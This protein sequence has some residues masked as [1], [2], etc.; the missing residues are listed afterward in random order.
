M[1]TIEVYESAMCCSTG[2]CGPDVPQELVSFSA[3]V[4]WLKNQGA[5][6][7]R[8]N[9][10]SEAQAFAE[11]PQVLQ[12][13]KVSGSEH[14]PLVLVDGTVARTGTYPARAELARWAGIEGE[15][16]TAP[17]PGGRPELSMVAASGGCCGGG[18]TGC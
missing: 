3:D 13:L 4:D 18:S 9:L 2:V 15:E 8:F 11:N 12:F 6:V 1:S 7:N 10:G 16:T 5:T 14:L 17:A